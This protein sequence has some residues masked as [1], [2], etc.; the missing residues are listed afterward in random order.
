ALSIF[1]VLFYF[2]EFIIFPLYL[3]AATRTVKA[4]SAAGHSIAFMIYSS[5]SAGLQLVALVFVFIA[6]NSAFNILRS[7]PSKGLF[8][9]MAVIQLIATL[10]FLGQMVWYIFL[11]FRTRD[12]LEE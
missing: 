10:V 12:F 11:L 9:T 6:Y 2:A 3:W 8:I 5:V 1:V 4:R 7:P